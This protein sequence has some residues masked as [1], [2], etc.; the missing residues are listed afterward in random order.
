MKENYITTAYDLSKS[1][2]EKD[3]GSISV[4]SNNGTIFSIKYYL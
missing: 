1:I 4:D 2:I 3:N